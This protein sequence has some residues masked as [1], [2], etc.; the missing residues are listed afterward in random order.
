MILVL[1]W[2]YREAV[3][4]LKPGSYQGIHARDREQVTWRCEGIKEFTIPYKG[5]D[6][7]I[8]VTSGL[9]KCQERLWS[10]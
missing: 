6:I 1:Q 2:C 8:F 4:R 10:V 9:A 3:L 7:N 5:M